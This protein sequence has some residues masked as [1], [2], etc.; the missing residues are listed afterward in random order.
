M[1]SNFSRCFSFFLDFFLFLS[2]GVVFYSYY[3]RI[4]RSG[5]R[6]ITAK[7]TRFPRLFLRF[8]LSSCCCSASSFRFHQW[9]WL[10][11]VQRRGKKTTSRPMSENGLEKILKAET[12]S[13]QCR[14]FFQFLLIVMTLLLVRWLYFLNVDQCLSLAWSWFAFASLPVS[15]TNEFT[16]FEI[17]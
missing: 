11:N 16:N 15:S 14:S 5:H 1:S 13:S 3:S 6:H 12:W 8:F 9:M 10:L 4:D 2:V 7:I 17:V